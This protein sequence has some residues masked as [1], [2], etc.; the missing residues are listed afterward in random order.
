MTLHCRRAMI[1]PDHPKHSIVAQCRLVAISR[2]CF[3]HKPASETGANLA[4]MR[5]IDEQFMVTPWVM[6]CRRWPA[7]CAGLAMRWG[8]SGSAG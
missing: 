4:L 3:Y 7:I 8:A 5:V 2:S 1:E 6:A